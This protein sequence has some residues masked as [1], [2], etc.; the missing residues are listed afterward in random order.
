MITNIN[1]WKQLT[2]TLDAPYRLN[3][4]HKEHIEEFLQDIVNI[5]DK[6][7]YNKMHK[8]VNYI[9]SLKLNKEDS[10]D[11]VKKIMTDPATAPDIVDIEFIKSHLNSIVGLLN[12]L[13]EELYYKD[14]MEFDKDMTN[15]PY[16]TFECAMYSK[17]DKV[18]KLALQINEKIN[19]NNFKCIYKNNILYIN[20]ID[21]LNEKNRSIILK[22]LKDSDAINI[23]ESLKIKRKI[24]EKIQ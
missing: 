18:K 4:K 15:E 12:K 21:K 20:N 17:S 6:E 11:T 10:V 19:K 13:P 24:Y 22:I 16:S 7:T 8:Y 5:K 14:S 2:T 23:T 1:E 9:L 3:N